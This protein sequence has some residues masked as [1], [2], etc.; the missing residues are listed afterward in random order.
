MPATTVL[1]LGKR[2]PFKLI[3]VSKR[4]NLDNELKSERERREKISD[5]AFGNRREQR[6]RLDSLV[7]MSTIYLNRF[8][9]TSA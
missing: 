2:R 7:H 5:K 4:T 9:A 6:D 8:Q 3:I 1:E